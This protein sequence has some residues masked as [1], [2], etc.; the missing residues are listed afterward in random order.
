MNDAAANTIRPQPMI[1]VAD[2]EHT[3]LWYQRILGAKSDHGGPEYERLVVDGQLV[4]Q[5]HNLAIGHH[6]GTIGDPSLPVGNGVALWFE[7]DSFD[8]AVTRIREFGAHIETDV[9]VNPNA[10][11]RE[12]WLRDPDHYLVVFAESAA[13]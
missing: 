7:T 2:V 1:A 11:H 8:A 9:H 13:Q 10:K 12:I 5:L 3:S 4:L 6:H